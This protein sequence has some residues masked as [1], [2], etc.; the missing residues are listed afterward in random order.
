MNYEDESQ[1]YS[2]TNDIRELID[3][4][5]EHNTLGE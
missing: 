4:S 3:G 5:E 1:I 2:M